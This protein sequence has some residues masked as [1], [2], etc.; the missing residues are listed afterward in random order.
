M[1]EQPKPIRI[2]SGW[3]D[4][5]CCQTCQ[6]WRPHTLGVGWCVKSSTYNE[7]TEPTAGG[8]LSTVPTF[9]CTNWKAKP[10]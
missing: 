1:T 4:G 9:A 5:V 7:Q 10:E 3:P 8:G 6:H 2:V